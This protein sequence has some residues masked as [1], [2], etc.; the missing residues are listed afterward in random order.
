M[1]SLALLGTSLVICTAF[2]KD[3][4]TRPNFLAV[5]R[6]S[7]SSSLYLVMRCTGWMR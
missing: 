6:K 5:A 3:G 1:A 4:V 7:P 2:S